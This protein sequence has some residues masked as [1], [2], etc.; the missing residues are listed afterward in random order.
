[1]AWGD[2]VEYLVWCPEIGETKDDAARYRI[3]NFYD[4]AQRAA[5][6]WAQEWDCGDYGL[7][8]GDEKEVIVCGPLPDE[9][10]TPWRVWGET[11]PEYRA[12]EA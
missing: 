1:M 9:T 7:L 4:A 6:K 8:G 10:E 11:V 5:V 2:E 12:V 3:S